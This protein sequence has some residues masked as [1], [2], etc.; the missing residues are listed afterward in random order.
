MEAQAI[1]LPQ[2]DQESDRE[3]QQNISLPPADRGRDAW[4]FLVTAFFVEA[5]IWGIV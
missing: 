2:R 3:G 5:L 1:E 4:L